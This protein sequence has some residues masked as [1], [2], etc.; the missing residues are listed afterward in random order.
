MKL[1]VALCLVAAVSAV[2][3]GDGQYDYYSAKQYLGNYVQD[4]RG[5]YKPENDGQY[6]NPNARRFN[7]V[8]FGSNYNKP[9]ATFAS[10]RSSVLPPLN[11]NNGQVSSGASVS[12]VNGQTKSVNG[13]TNTV[14][15]FNPAPIRGNDVAFGAASRYAQPATNFGRY[16]FGRSTGGFDQYGRSGILRL[17]NEVTDNGYRYAYETDNK[18][19]AEQEGRIINRGRSDEGVNANGF[20][21]YVGPDGRTY[22]VDYTAD[23]NG[24]QAYGDHLPTPPPVP[25]AIQRALDYVAR[26]RKF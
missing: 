16:S 23:E 9:V 11:E 4:K 2:D 10:P 3:R 25:E 24:F 22:R 15:S 18:I 12:N 8:S 14:R 1:L 20:Y 21:A 13:I 6:Y 7:T 19:V 5:Q 17:D 26:T